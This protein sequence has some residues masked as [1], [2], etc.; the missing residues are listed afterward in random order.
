MQYDFRRD[1]RSC[2]VVCFASFAS[3]FN[4]GDVKPTDDGILAD[5]E[6]AFGPSGLP[7]WPQNQPFERE[8]LS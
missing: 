8:Q 5:V 3:C 4:D 2:F 1:F 6:T 7:Y